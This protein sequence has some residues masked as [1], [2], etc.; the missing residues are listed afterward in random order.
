[1]VIIKQFSTLPLYNTRDR[2]KL[3]FDGCEWNKTLFMS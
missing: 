2:K 3:V 1:L